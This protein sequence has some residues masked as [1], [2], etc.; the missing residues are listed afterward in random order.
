MRC[1]RVE[2]KTRLTGNNDISLGIDVLPAS[3]L[4]PLPCSSEP[5][6]KTSGFAEILDRLEAPSDS[7]G[8]LVFSGPGES[9][10]LPA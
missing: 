3:P 1:A 7:H 9:P 2:D 10:R 8:F 5:V 4:A 6:T